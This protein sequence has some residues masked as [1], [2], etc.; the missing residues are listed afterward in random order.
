V[1]DLIGVDPVKGPIFFTLEQK[2][3]QPVVF[4]RQVRDCIQCHL[5]P[6]TVNVPG[7]MLRSVRTNDLGKPMSQVQNFVGGHNNILKERWGGWYVTGTHDGE[8]HLG[9]GF[10]GTNPPTPDSLKQNSN[11]T[12]LKDKFDTSKYPAAES[13]AVALLVLDHTVRM[14]NYIVQAQ[15]ETR[16]AQ[17]ERKHSAIPL[18]DNSNWRIKNSGE[19]LLTYMLFRD[20]GALHGK[21]T[22]TSDFTRRFSQSGPRDKQGRSLFEFDLNK[23]VFRYP[24]SYMIYTKSFDALP[25]EMKEYLWKRFREILSGNDKSNRYGTLTAEDRQAVLEILLDTKPEFRAW[26]NAHPN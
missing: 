17:E 3:N 5:G 11:I 9:N 19:S 16:T 15:Y 26:W 24:C 12:S 2:P 20:E 25:Q 14:Q 4:K 22:G 18:V 7:L 10:Y 6:E 23:R 21:I 8:E 13:D 1:I